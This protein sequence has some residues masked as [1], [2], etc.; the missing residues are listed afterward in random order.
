SGSR[1]ALRAVAGQKER[2]LDGVEV[3]PDA[4]SLV[5]AGGVLQVLA[6]LL[7]LAEQ[8]GDALALGEEGEHLRRPPPGRQAHGRSC[9]GRGPSSAP[10]RC[11]ATSARRTGPQARRRSNRSADV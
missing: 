9:A 4:V 5:L 3:G 2:V 11:P 6:E 7:V 10:P 1:L 8:L